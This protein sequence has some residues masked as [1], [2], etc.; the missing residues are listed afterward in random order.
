MINYYLLIKPG[1]IMG[2]LITVAAGFALGAPGSFNFWLFL[3]TLLGLAAVIASACV[4]N[5]YIDREIDKK[6]KR[7]QNRA[8]AKGRIS[9]RNAIIFALLLGLVG[10]FILFTYTNLLT[11]L[12]ATVGFFVYVLIYSLWKSR[13]IYA[14]AIGSIAGAVPPLVGYCAAGNEFNLGAILLF[15][16]LVLWQMPHFFSIAIY[17]FDDYQAA[18]IPLYPIKK[19]IPKTKVRMVIYIICFIIATASLTLLNY[20]GFL[21]LTIGTAIGIFWLLFCLKGFKRTDN[22]V[23]ARQMFRI[24]LVAI[25]AVSVLIPFDL[26]T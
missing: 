18:L 13:T 14:T 10:F 22:E 21:Y 6:M 17:R 20:T 16:I 15:A 23:W 8:L 5:N 26:I 2:N 24:S 4:F 3:M 7:T 9:T 11:T 25:T 1:I 19:G 12:V